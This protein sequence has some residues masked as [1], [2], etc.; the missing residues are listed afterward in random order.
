MFS[1][2][3]IKNK[4]AQSI[5]SK[6][7]LNVKEE[8]TTI[9]PQSIDNSIT[10]DSKPRGLQKIGQLLLNLAKSTATAFIP[11]ALNLIKQLGVKEFET[12]ITE[13]R[14]KNP[15]LN[16]E[17]IIAQVKENICP[18]NEQLDLIILQRNGL[19]Q[20]LN[21]TGTKLD[22]LSVTIN[23][24][25]TFAST[26]EF[27]VKILKGASF[28]INQAAK[29]IPL[30]PGA[31]VSAVNDLDTASDTILFKPDGT[32]NIPPIKIS[33]SQVSP[34]IAIVQA[35]IVKCVDLLDQLDSLIL[36]CNPNAVLSSLSDSIN[37]T[38]DNELLAEL[39]EN[40]STYKGFILELETREYTPT[41]NQ[42]RAVG[43]NKSGITMIATEYS[44]ASDPQ[45]LIDELKFII[46]RDD[47]KAY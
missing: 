5:A 40:E 16:E 15:D 26:L 36:I 4:R 14:E 32:P 8:S 17:E 1:P 24:G 38:Y 30:I 34:A 35:I 6:D 10:E 9:D 45:V 43:I 19:V 31:V 22:G 44:F 12:Q 21:S 25:A 47:L 18:T 41:V 23:F 3:E 7:N 39:S 27:L 2:Q 13:L 37:N 29:L 11:V 20:K 33:A 46:D 28:T 42:N